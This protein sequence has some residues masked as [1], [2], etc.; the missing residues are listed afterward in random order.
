MYIISVFHKCHYLLELADI[1]VYRFYAVVRFTGNLCIFTSFDPFFN[2]Q[3][4]V[5]ERPSHVF[6][7]RT[8]WDKDVLLPQVFQITHDGPLPTTEYPVG[9]IFNSEQP[10]L[11]KG[12]IADTV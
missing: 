5:R 9:N 7:S 3:G 6:N 11:H 8:K 10:A 12:F 1:V 4:T 2:N